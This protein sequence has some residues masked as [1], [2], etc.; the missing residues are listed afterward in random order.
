MRKLLCRLLG[1][2]WR[3]IW[4]GKHIICRC[5]RCGDITTKLVRREPP[6]VAQGGEDGMSQMRQAVGNA[7]AGLAM[8]LIGAHVGLALDESLVGG[9]LIGAG[10]ALFGLGYAQYGR[11]IRGE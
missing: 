3:Y 11:F 6:A 4:P 8:L 1:H 10:V 2:R 9:V 5:R 7:A